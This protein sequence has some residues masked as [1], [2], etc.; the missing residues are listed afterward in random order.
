MVP[1]GINLAS[2]F[3]QLL[4]AI[5]LIEALLCWDWVGVCVLILK[6]LTCQLDSITVINLCL[7]N[8]II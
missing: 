5:V 1:L 8:E 3:C 6:H 2:V 4:C 7:L